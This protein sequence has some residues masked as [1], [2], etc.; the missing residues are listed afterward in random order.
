MG[1]GEVNENLQQLSLG[2]RRLARCPPLL[3]LGMVQPLGGEMLV[4]SLAR[5]L[6]LRRADPQIDSRPVKILDEVL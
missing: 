1:S 6:T 2:T 5:G 4:E 3:I